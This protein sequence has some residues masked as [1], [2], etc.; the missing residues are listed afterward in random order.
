MSR[1]EAAATIERVTAEGVGRAIKGDL[2]QGARRFLSGGTDSSTVVG[3]M[4]R[5]SAR[6]NAFSIGF[7]EAA[8]N[9]LEYAASRRAT[10]GPPS[11][12]AS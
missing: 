7:G 6:V 12:R 11:T 1:V 5:V 9:E 10:S 3:L 4:A 8:Y 2:G